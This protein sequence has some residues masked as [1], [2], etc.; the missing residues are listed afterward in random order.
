MLVK[1][2]TYIY[3]VMQKHM[4]MHVIT[5]VQC[6]VECKPCSRLDNMRTR[7][8]PVMSRKPKI[9]SHQRTRGLGGGGGGGG[10]LLNDTRTKTIHALSS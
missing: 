3:R 1:R 5:L 7:K 6:S 8:H 10:V 2:H 9:L 4:V